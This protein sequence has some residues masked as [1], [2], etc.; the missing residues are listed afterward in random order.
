MRRIMVLALAL[1]WWAG[2]ALSRLYAEPLSPQGEI[3]T[4]RTEDGWSIAMIRHRAEGSAS[5]PPVLLCHGI[6]ANA[7]NLDLDAEHS[8]ARWLAAHGR[9]T[10]A[11]SLR[12]VGDSDRPDPHAGRSFGYSMDTYAAEDLPAALARV[13]ELTGAPQVDFVGHSMGGLVGYIYLAR[14]GKGIGSAA[15]LGSPTRFVWGHSRQQDLARAGGLLA[16]SIEYLDVPALAHMTA[17]FH[18]KVPTLFD[19]L[20]YNPD[21]VSPTLWRKFVATGVGS[22]SGGVLR[23]FTLWMQ[24]DKMLSADGTMD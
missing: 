17:P 14:G 15:F 12:G 24:T 6:S 9:E 13:R 19:V 5:G 10:F 18:G 11:M 3:V 1:P 20:L 21:N 16:D 22:I 8:L 7:R 4:A 2:C 23:Q